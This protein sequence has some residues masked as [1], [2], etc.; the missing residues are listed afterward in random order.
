MILKS[1]SPRREKQVVYASALKVVWKE[2]NNRGRRDYGIPTLLS[3]EITRNRH[4]RGGILANDGEPRGACS[5]DLKDLHNPGN[6]SQTSTHVPNRSRAPQT[7]PFATLS[8]MSSLP[9]PRL[10][11]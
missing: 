5:T 1:M 11:I 8:N 3:T 2:G 9:N 4:V 10:L 6:R 7:S